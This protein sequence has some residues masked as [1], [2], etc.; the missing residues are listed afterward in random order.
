VQRPGVIGDK[1]SQGG[2]SNHAALVQRSQDGHFVVV[3]FAEA[4]A[5]VEVDRERMD[6]EGLERVEVV[7]IHVPDHE[8]KHRQIYHVQ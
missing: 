5:M 7:P 4:T 8:I 2:F 1:N 3:G 6:P